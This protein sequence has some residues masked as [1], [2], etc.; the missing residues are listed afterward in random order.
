MKGHCL[1]ED[2]RCAY[3]TSNQRALA[4]HFMHRTKLF[5]RLPQDDKITEINDNLY[6]QTGEADLCNYYHSV[7]H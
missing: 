5:Y 6:D 7:S 1:F 2:N 3:H 4:E